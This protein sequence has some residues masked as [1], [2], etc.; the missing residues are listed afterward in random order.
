MTAADYDSYSIREALPGDLES[1]IGLIAD[2][3]IGRIREQKEEKESYRI[4]FDSILT[5]DYMSFVVMENSASELVACLQLM[6]LPHLSRQGVT[7]AQVES[8]RVRSDLRGRGLGRRMMEYACNQ[9]SKRGCGLMQLTTDKRRDE[10]RAF[11]EAVGFEPS[12]LGFKR[13][14]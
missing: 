11:Y 2:D 13:V 9:A 10:A 4:A 8:V 3:K 5:A 7:R 14:L 1:V 6:I 12:H